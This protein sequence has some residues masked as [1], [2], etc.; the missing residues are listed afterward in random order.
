MPQ[1]NLTVHRKENPEFLRRFVEACR[2]AGVAAGQYE[3]FP[4]N[5]AVIL[6]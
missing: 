6:V 3:S 2:L 4:Q 5:I 1:R